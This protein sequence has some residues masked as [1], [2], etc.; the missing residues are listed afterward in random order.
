VSTDDITR[1]LVQ[2]LAGGRSDCG[3]VRA[4]NEDAFAIDDT[5]GV[6]LVADGMGGHQ[7]GEI[8]SRIAA[9]SVHGFILRSQAADIDDWPFGQLPELSLDGNRLRNAIALANRRVWR[10]A[11]S[12]QA[13]DGMGTTIVAALISG[14]RVI[15]GHVGDSRLYAWGDGHLEQ[16]T[17]DDT[18]AARLPEAQPVDALGRARPGVLTNVLG[19][20]E[21][22][23]VHITERPWAAGDKLLLC[24]DGLHGVVG[25]DALAQVLRDQAEPREAARVLVDLALARGSRDNVTAVV[26]RRS[27]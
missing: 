5:L 4:I 27:L 10:T 16:V 23:S 14:E 22:V 11:R 8:A 6:Y 12:S 2:V 17:E 15:V 19:L 13:L 21:L 24:S 18:W 26:I 9:D 7:A 20:D 3:P 1:P 25:D